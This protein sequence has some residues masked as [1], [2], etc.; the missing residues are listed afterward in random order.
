MAEPTLPITGGCLCGAVRYRATKAPISVAH[1]HC[2]NCQKHTGA[3]FVTSIGFTGDSFSW[4]KGTPAMYSSSENGHRGFCPHCG[5]TLS[6]HWSDLGTDWVHAG[7]LDDPEIATPEF[8]FMTKS[9]PSWVKLD[10]G[11]AQYHTYPPKR[12]GS[13]DDDPNYKG[14]QKELNDTE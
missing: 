2:K 8:H 14:I 4:V 13:T 1:C 6:F 12:G 3:A 7:S 11:L 5:S 9:K 10:D